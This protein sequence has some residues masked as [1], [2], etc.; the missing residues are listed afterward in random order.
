MKMKINSS[1][2]I[3]LF[4][5]FA[6]NY[7]YSQTI[8]EILSYEKN[9]KNNNI[10][11]SENEKKALKIVNEWTKGNKVSPVTRGNNG[12]IELIYGLSQPHILTAILQVTDIQ[13]EVGETITSIHLGDTARWVVEHIKANTRYGYQ[14]HIVVKPKDINLLTSLIVV[15]DKRTYHLQLKSN[16]KLYYPM[17][18]FHYPS[19][20]I[21]KTQ[22]D[23]SSMNTNNKNNKDIDSYLKSLDFN[24]KIKGNANFKPVRI[25]NDGKKT[26]IEL[27]N[28]IKSGNIPLLMT[29][30]PE[31]KKPV[32]VNYRYQNNKFIVDA[33]F[34]KAILISGVGKKQKKITLIRE[35]E[36]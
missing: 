12:E 33:V 25:Y 28:S 35:M 18:K 22:E 14:D 27:P 15:T 19:S 11:L 8:E 4:I 17:V 26:I 20:I 3:F 30:E 1:I 7:A 32:I 23:I 10:V 24:Y 9:N 29:I 13:F 36:K 21:L 16:D 6:T 5:I 2:I 34:N 31:S